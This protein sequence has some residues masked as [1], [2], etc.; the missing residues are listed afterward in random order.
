MMM[1][2]FSLLPLA[3]ANLPSTL[4]FP[5]PDFDPE[6]LKVL[7]AASKAFA[8]DDCTELKKQVKVG[9]KSGIKFAE[10][11][12]DN[13]VSQV[14]AANPM[15]KPM[16]DMAKGQI[17]T[18]VRDYLREA[19]DTHVCVLLAQVPKEFK[20]TLIERVT[21]LSVIVQDPSKC[22]DLKE[23]AAGIIKQ[24]IAL[25]ATNTRESLLVILNNAQNKDVREKGN[26]SHKLMV[27]VLELLAEDVIKNHA[28]KF[29]YNEP[30][31]DDLG[32]EG[33]KDEL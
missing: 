13:I 9:A 33:E 3:T 26:L 15:V 22:E 8:D 28:C 17:F 4:D 5:I 19:I 14:A 23:T 7:M 1:L 11:Q 20:S 2:L 16:A 18:V 31:E 10:G 6:T 29:V 30:E 32:P 27:E 12:F 24:G 25:W 21:K